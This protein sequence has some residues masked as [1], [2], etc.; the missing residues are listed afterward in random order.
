M[1]GFSKN[2]THSVHENVNSLLLK[3]KQTHYHTT[4]INVSFTRELQLLLPMIDTPRVHD[5]YGSV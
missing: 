5:V 1:D 2:A 4:N 3:N